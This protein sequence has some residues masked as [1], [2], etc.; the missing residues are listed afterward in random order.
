MLCRTKAH[1]Y[2]LNWR[3]L[4]AVTALFTFWFDKQ[5]FGFQKCSVACFDKWPL[6][7]I[8]ERRRDDTQ[9]FV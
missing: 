4:V 2:I 1:F 7:I 8:D 9:L 5:R 6:I 3:V